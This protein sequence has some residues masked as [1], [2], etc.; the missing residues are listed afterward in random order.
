MRA[1]IVGYLVIAAVVIAVGFAGRALS[2]ASESDHTP[3]LDQTQAMDQLGLAGVT[4]SATGGCNDWYGSSC[5]SLEQ[6]NQSTVVGLIGLR[7]ASGCPVTITAGTEVGHTDDGGAHWAGAQVTLAKNT[8]L[9]Q[10]FTRV[11]DG[12]DPAGVDRPQW[13]TSAGVTYQDTGKH[14]EVHFPLR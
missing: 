3:K 4:W 7:R 1:R 12:A 11:Y 13:K 6:I 5:T 8:C 14:W 10:Y 9:V 2:Q